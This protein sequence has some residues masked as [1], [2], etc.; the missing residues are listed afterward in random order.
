MSKIRT[1]PYLFDEEKSI[2]ITNLKK[3]GYLKMNTKKGGSLVW[4]QGERETGKISIISF[5]DNTNSFIV[6]DYKC[7]D[8]NYKYKVQLIATPSNLGTGNIWYFLCPFTGKKCRKLHLINE[9]FMHR[10]ALSSGMYSKQTKSKKWRQMEKVYGSYFDNEKYYKELYSKNFKTHYNGK[11]T[12][13]Y[14]K[15]LEKINESESFS[16]EEIEK[17]YLM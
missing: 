12:K 9:R 2:D 1:F 17:L 13:R 6:L 5:I 15:L 11:P 10:S 8:K 7:N 3:W 14:L 4:K 16:T